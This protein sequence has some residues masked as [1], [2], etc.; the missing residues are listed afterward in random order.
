MASEWLNM[1]ALWELHRIG[2]SLMVKASVLCHES[3]HAYSEFPMT[4][5]LLI[6]M[7]AEEWTAGIVE[8]DELFA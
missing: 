3:V 8:E 6:R 2:N 5:E 1:V 4:A 7:D